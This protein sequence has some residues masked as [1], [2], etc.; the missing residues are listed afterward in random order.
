[1]TPKAERIAAI[2][3]PL[4]RGKL[5]LLT[6]ANLDEVVDRICGAG[7]AAPDAAQEF[8]N[9]VASVVA[10]HMHGAMDGCGLRSMGAQLLIEIIA[11]RYSSGGTDI[12]WSAAA[13]VADAVADAVAETAPHMHGEMD[14]R[15][16]RSMG[17]QLRIEII[18]TRHSPS[19][20]ELDVDVSDRA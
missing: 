8:A 19:L 1:M 3:A 2:E 5:I 16:L 17:A 7:P 11:T 4:G 6:E 9:H 10:R 15:G 12:G 18:A 14:R 13:A 20:I